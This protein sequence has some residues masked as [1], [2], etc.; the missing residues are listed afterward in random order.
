MTKHER[1]QIAA[2][3]LVELKTEATTGYP[4]PMLIEALVRQMQIAMA[5]AQLLSEIG[6]SGWWSNRRKDVLIGHNYKRTKTKTKRKKKKID[7]DNDPRYY[8]RN[9]NRNSRW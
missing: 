5:E 2:D 1:V 4:K 9:F 7:T 3:A 8:E 6:D